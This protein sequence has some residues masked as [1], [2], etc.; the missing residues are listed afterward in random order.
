MSFLKRLF[1]SG[2]GAGG[3]R[4]DPVEHEGYTIVPEPM[5]EGGQYRLQAVIRKSLDGVERE[6][7]LIRAD[8][9][10]DAEQ[11]AQFAIVKA[12]QVIAEQGDRMFA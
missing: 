11:A 5:P 2:G 9:F 1:G 12:R 7:R 4:F 10:P 6:H 8:L 3:P